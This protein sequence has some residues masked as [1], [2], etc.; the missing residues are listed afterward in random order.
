MRRV[1]VTGI[2]A[3]SALGLNVREFWAGLQSGK[4]GI[5]KRTF[6]PGD[7]LE[8]TAPV[9]LRTPSTPCRNPRAG[10]W[11]VLTAFHAWR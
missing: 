10:I 5:V 3:V 11:P 1:V 7:G 6:G 4:C 8:L 2:G 9:A